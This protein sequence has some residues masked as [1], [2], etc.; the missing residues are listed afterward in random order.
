MSSDKPTDLSQAAPKAFEPEP[1]AVRRQTDRVLNAA[2]FR[3]TTAQRAFLRF[4]VEKVLA[5]EA[6]EVKGF[7]VATQVFGRGEDF[8]QATDPIVSI[9]AN[10]LRRALEHYY[11]TAGRG[12][13]I[14]ID[15]PKGTYVPTFHQQPGT[16][17]TIGTGK[18]AA[19]TEPDRS[20]PTLLIRPFRN[21][22]GEAKLDYLGIGLAT[23]LAMGITRH[24]EA[25]VIIMKSPDGAQRMPSGAGARFVVDGSIQSDG[26]YIRISVALADTTTGIQ[27]WGETYPADFDAG[28]MIAFQEKVAGAV[29]ANIASE[30]GVITKALSPE[31]K[32]KPPNALE[33]YEAILR[34][35]EFTLKF[36]PD[37]FFR[38]Y[39]ALTLAA[40]NEPDCGLV[41]SMLARLYAIN[42]GLELFNQET[43]I[44][45]AI[46][47]AAKGV[48]LE[49][50]NQRV[51][52]IMA[53]VLLIKGDVE[54]G[55]AE[56]ERAYRLNPNSLLWLENIGYLMTLFGDWQRGPALIRK[57]LQHNPFYNVAVHYALWV[58]WVRQKEYLQAYNETLNF[59]LPG[60]FWDPLLKAAA[61]GLT[62][63]LAEGRQAVDDLLARKPDFP[64]RGRML[65]RYYLKFDDIVERTII[66]LA[67][68]GLALSHP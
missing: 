9:Q 36:T 61:C 3:G 68:S 28:R 20:W 14:R 45:T 55:L 31:S 23:D 12:D 21:L 47:Y 34:F 39:D 5:G 38:A 66:G 54:G 62:G 35:Y 53:Y 4:V 7:T 43:P 51:R 40:K 10:K 16:G 65:I 15:I 46:S 49:P 59:R 56:T 25:R 24:Q 26:K 58:D 50:A 22:T 41:W 64:Q 33:T 67:N 57:A 30:A 42:F 11:L 44:E 19:G 6:D 2:E 29:A 1:D 60:L 17:K 18:P 32:N 27:L 13:P 48:H 63:N 52:L 8:D 37:T